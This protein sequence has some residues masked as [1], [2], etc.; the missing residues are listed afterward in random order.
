MIS[1][2]MEN[3]SLLL[4][5]IHV[6]P[7]CCLAH[8]TEVLRSNLDVTRPEMG[9]SAIFPLKSSQVVGDSKKFQVKSSQVTPKLIDWE[10]RWPMKTEKDFQCIRILSL[11]QDT[12]TLRK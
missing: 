8:T 12:S 11:F 10:V 4:Y 2:A 1:D 5:H 6:G 3:L 9:K 7:L